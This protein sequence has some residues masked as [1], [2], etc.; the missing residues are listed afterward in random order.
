MTAPARVRDRSV[1][2]TPWSA[3]GGARPTVL[4]RIPLAEPPARLAAYA[5]LFELLQDGRP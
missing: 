5:A 2:R 3:G 4:S 1:G